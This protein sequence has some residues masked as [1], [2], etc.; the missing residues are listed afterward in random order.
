[1]DKKAKVKFCK[2]CKKT[3]E[4]DYDN[5]YK[6]LNGY[7]NYCKPCSILKNKDNYAKHRESYLEQKRQ[8]W[9]DNKESITEYRSDN[10]EFLA[11]ACRKRRKSRLKTDPIFRLRKNVPERIRN[12]L[13][14][15]G[16]RKCRNT[17]SIVGLNN[18]ELFDYLCGTFEMN[19]GIPRSSIPWE[20]MHIDHIIPLSSALTKEEIYK[21]C[22][23]TNLQLLFAEDNVEK[24]NSLDWEI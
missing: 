8:Y 21:L 6:K 13:K 16:I 20:M 10:K 18:T 19:Y 11:I 1:M 22:Y 9:K 15:K 2:S 24:S 4:L 12:F 14:S 3:K 5:F 23:Y 7:S 17:I